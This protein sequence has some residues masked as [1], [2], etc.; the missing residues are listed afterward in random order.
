MYPEDDAFEWRYA[1]IEDRK[2]KPI[3][4]ALIKR[5]INKGRSIA[6]ASAFSLSIPPG[7]KLERCP[8][9]SSSDSKLFATVYGFSYV[10]CDECGTCYVCNPPSHEAIRGAYNSDYYTAANKLLLAN[11]DTISDRVEHIARPK[12]E[13]VK[14]YAPSGRWLDI[15]CGVGEVLVSARDAGYK[16]TGI[17]TN[18][19]EASFAR[20]HFGLTVLGQY[21][22]EGNAA[23]FAGQYEIISLFSVLEHVPDPR[24]IVRTISSIQTKGGIL[25]IETPHFP[26]VSTLCQAAFPNMVNRM[27]HPPLH[28]F[29]FSLRAIEKILVEFGYS[30]KARWM[31]GQDFYE[32]LTTITELH[33]LH[34]GR[35]ETAMTSITPQVQQAIDDI[36]LSDEMLVVAERC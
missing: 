19:M 27:M 35:L 16:V 8:V 29:L 23:S 9:C 10:E 11:P 22:H 30:I 5:N 31:F 21:I 36:G 32:F 2:G 26:S 13:F 34:G 1:V 6:A 33:G 17:E 15:G 4:T 14:K 25:V 18:E 12:V 20:D 24:S 7:H 3:D 28:L